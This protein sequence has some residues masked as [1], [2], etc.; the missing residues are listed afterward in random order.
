MIT[1]W[2]AAA[3]GDKSSR[4]LADI[5]PWLL[6]LVG[7]VLVGSAVIYVVRRSFKSGVTSSDAGFTLQD[8]RDLHAAGEL[9]DEQFER[10]KAMMIG[11]LRSDASARFMQS[12]QGADPPATNNPEQTSD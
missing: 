11:R 10:A 4:L 12:K 1:T 3:S 7:V 8:L 2:I 9:T 6:V 5:L